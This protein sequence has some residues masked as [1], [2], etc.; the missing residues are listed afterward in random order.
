MNK[1][2]K[3]V[4]PF[5]V[6][7]FF[8]LGLIVFSG[9]KWEK[10]KYDNFTDI[11]VPSKV[12]PNQ[13]KIDVLHYD[14]NIDLDPDKRLL[15]GDAIIT[16]VII[17][18]TLTSIDL[19]FYDNLKISSL[20]LNGIN[21]E[22]SNTDNILQ[23]KKGN[24]RD[25]FNLEVVYSGTPKHAGLAGFVFGEINKTNVAYNLNEPDF[26]GTWFPC[27]DMPSDKAFLDMRITNDSSQVSAS[28]GILVDVKLNGARKTYHWKTLRPIATYLISVYS[29]K[30]VTF[31]DQY[32]SQN[33]KDTLPLLY[34]VFHKDLENAKK[35]FEDHPKYLDF[36]AKTFG[37]YPFIK[38]KYGVAEFLW[39]YG[40]ME[41]QTLTGVGS[42]FVTGKKYFNDV[43]VHELSH[44][45][46][47]DAVSPATWKDIWLN[48]GFAT[49]SEVLWSEHLGGSKALQAAMLSKF[50][51]D[52]VGK[53][54]N[55]KDNLFG[56]T[57]YD[58]GAWVLHMLRRETGDTLFF[59]ILRT[60][61]ETYKFK[62]AST[63]DFKKICQ[64]IAGKDFTRF[65]DQWVYKG[66]GQ[67][68]LKYSWS[69]ES[70]PE[71]FKLKIHTE[72]TQKEYG[73]YVFPLEFRITM[74]NGRD[75]TESFNID[76]RVQE[77]NVLLKDLP[78]EIEPDPNGW[79]LA[80]IKKAK[81]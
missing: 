37:E 20:K 59:K 42:N 36:F 7:I 39:Q 24:V 43:Y 30:Y 79:L 74:V 58:K 34:Y 15:K 3:I 26:A 70:A 28:N 72:Q 12:N 81:K 57:V 11:G 78:R 19:D 4:S 32:I 9:G 40:A 25:T 29:A 35:D 10:K 69:V 31:S 13:L 71:G 6:S 68:E 47:G 76:S 75:T 21:A 52:F 56:P 16:G 5:L 51:D 48:E 27:N 62:N 1:R 54:Y 44:H 66:E 53:L 41:H 80:S 33:G 67:I 77:L 17:D 46:W 2:I 8:I 64:T 73:T 18:S 50:K 14:L 65:F 49:Y 60:W 63:D 23:I 45:W 22:Y 61:F 38:E 55:P